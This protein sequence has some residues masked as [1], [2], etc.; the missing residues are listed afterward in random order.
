FG[1]DVV[2]GCYEDLDECDLAVL[3]GSNMAWCHP[4]LYQR[5]IAAR[6]KRGTKLVVI[7]PR[8]TPTCETADLHLPV[9]AGGDIALFNGLLAYLHD[10]GAVNGAWIARNVA[11]FAEAS[12]SAKADAP[13]LTATAEATGVRPDNLLQFYE[14]FF[15]TERVVTLYSQGVNQSAFG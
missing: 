2:P 13:T 1:E 15:R 11:G 9:S 3:V 14:L 7:D 8:R 5:L 4:V 12:A 10:I 6:E